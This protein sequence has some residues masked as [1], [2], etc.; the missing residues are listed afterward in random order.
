MVYDADDAGELATLRTLDIFIEEE[1]NV[2]VVS[3]PKG[4]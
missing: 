2:R 1:M 4:I 3:L